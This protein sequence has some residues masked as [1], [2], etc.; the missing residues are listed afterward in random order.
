[1][2]FTPVCTEKRARPGTPTTGTTAQGGGFTVRCWK[3]NGRHWVEG[4]AG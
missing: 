3:R 4:L 1:M 2:R